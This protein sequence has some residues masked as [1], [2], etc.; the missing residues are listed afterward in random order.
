MN[1]PTRL[2]RGGTSP[3][4]VALLPPGRRSVRN[5]AARARAIA[6]IAAPAAI[7]A[8]AATAKAA[9]GFGARLALL[10]KWAGI[11][12]VGGAV[13]AGA[14]YAVHAARTSPAPAPA[15]QVAVVAPPTA[16]TIV[17]PVAPAS[18]RPQRVAPA[19]PRP[20]A[21]VRPLAEPAAP[22][23]LAEETAMI[24]GARAALHGG[25]ASGALGAL[26]DYRARFPAGALTGSATIVRIEALVHLGRR[27]EARELAARFVAHN[28]RS[29]LVDRARSLAGLE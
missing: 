13:V 7:A 10:A 29:P 23:S 16:P 4:G 11:A 15:P 8:G 6:A 25:D 21:A 1:E 19:R 24:D 2:S 26:D 14:S 5:P 28:P 17:A 22:S 12:V 18:P 27:D 20:H 9:A 3:L